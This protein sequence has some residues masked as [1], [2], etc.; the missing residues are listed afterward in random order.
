MAKKSTETTLRKCIGSTRFGIEAH[1][2][3]IEDF[4]AQP[5]QKGR[6]WPNVQGALSAPRGAHEP[7]GAGRAPRPARRSGW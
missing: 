3:A 5:S 2:A 1:D 7:C 6:A 4:P